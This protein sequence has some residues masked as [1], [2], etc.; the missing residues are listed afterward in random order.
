MEE[1][2]SYRTDHVQTRALSIA[3]EDLIAQAHARHG[4]LSHESREQWLQRLP[5]RLRA[6]CDLVLGGTMSAEEIAYAL[7]VL[8]DGSEHALGDAGPRRH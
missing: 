5:E 1:P 6:L 4:G 3:T 7:A 8:I 2:A